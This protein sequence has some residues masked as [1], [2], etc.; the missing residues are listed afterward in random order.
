MCKLFETE[1]VSEK[2]VLDKK[3]LG[4]SL[5]YGVL[6]QLSDDVI[7][8]YAILENLFVSSSLYFLKLFFCQIADSLL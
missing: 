8:K 6:F 5:I 4:F 2:I 3:L 7:E 1:N